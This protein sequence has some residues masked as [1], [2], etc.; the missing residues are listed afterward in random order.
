MPGPYTLTLCCLHAWV[1]YPHPMLPACLGPEPCRLNSA[2]SHLN[3]EPCRLNPAACR[4]N[5]A[6]CHL[7][8]EPCRLHPPALQIIRRAREADTARLN[9]EYQRLVRGLVQQGALPRGGDEMLANPVLPEDIL[10]ETVPGVRG[11]G[12]VRVWGGGGMA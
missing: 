11:G 1:L 2:T 4:L 9:D 12:Y 10:R 6:T 7:N 8:P 5:S 3:P